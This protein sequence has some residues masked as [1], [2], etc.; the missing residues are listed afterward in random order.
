MEI[1]V[2]HQQ[3]PQPVTIFAIDGRINLGNTDRLEASAKEAF[4]KGT[5]NLVLDLSKVESITSAGL[6]TILVIHKMLASAKSTSAE[7]YSGKSKHLKLAGP[8]PQVH[9]VL[10][11]AGFTEILEIYDQMSAAV[12]SF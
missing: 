6:R 4:Q 2:S 11:T 1:I 5:R 8:T 12:A 3:E 9:R 10:T 7:G